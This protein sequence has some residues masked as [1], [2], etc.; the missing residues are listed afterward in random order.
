MVKMKT[1]YYDCLTAVQKNKEIRADV[2]CDCLA[3]YL[4]N[5]TYGFVNHGMKTMSKDDLR[6]SLDVALLT[7]KKYLF[8]CHITKRSFLLRGMECL[9]Y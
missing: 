6:K 8:F 1:L 5:Y 7:V 2:D 4:C 9:K 3:N